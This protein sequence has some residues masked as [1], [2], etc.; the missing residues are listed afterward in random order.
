V[1]GFSGLALALALLAGCTVSDRQ[2]LPLAAAFNDAGNA[3]AY[4]AAGRAFVARAPVF[5]GE[6]IPTPASASAIAWQGNEVLVALPQIKQVIV[7]RRLLALDESPVLFGKLGGHVRIFGSAGGIFDQN[8]ARLAKLPAAPSSIATYAGRMYALVAA[9]VFDVTLKNT[10]V[11]DQDPAPTIVGRVVARPNPVLLVS[12]SGFESV[13]GPA[14]VEGHDGAS[15]GNSAINNGLRYQV[16]ADGPRLRLEVYSG[17][18]LLRQQALDLPSETRV[19]LAVAG[20]RLALVSAEGL[21]IV[22]LDG[23]Q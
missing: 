4:I 5:I 3:V 20:Q 21:R 2:A 19:A 9:A 13:S 14:V 8:A 7:G 15:L 17:E 18:R 23:G 16:R 6:E 22:A 12:A 1:R 11:N 10:S